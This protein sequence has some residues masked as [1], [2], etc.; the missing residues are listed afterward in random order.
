M[1]RVT[2]R[3]DFGQRAPFV[4]LDS[5]SIL[6]LP[7]QAATWRREAADQGRECRGYS[8][9]GGDD[10][11]GGRADNTI[12]RA[13]SDGIEQSNIYLMSFSL[14]LLARLCL[15]F[16]RRPTAFVAAQLGRAGGRRCPVDTGGANVLGV[17]SV[18]N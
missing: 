9:T 10:E 5:R 8:I 17:Y 14:C 7:W 18:F 13:R 3:L 16:R 11:L 15:R 1:R 2:P 4:A 12:V 6:I